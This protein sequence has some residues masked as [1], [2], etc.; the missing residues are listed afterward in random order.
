M[1][2]SILGLAFLTIATFSFNASAQQKS[3]TVACDKAKSECIA[4]ADCCKD[5][6]DCKR[7]HAKRC[8][9]KCNLTLFKGINLTDAQ[10]IKITELNNGMKTSLNEMRSNAKTARENKDTTFNPREV[11]KDLR[12]KYLA[13][14]G[15]IL[16]DDQMD[17]FLKNYYI[18]GGDS[19]KKHFKG[20]P[21]RPGK[22]GK[23]FRKGKG[24]RQPRQ[25]DNSKTAK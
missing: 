13:D 12:S 7:H 17:T 10:K 5:G 4:G 11:R 8:D 25:G 23:D 22:G 2:K 20:Q 1:K 3:Q 15:K 21:G 14:L 16:S 24:P 19:H 9:M 18:N 6:K